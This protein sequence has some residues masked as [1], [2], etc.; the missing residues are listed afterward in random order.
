[1]SAETMFHHVFGYV[2]FQQLSQPTKMV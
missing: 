1:M 2:I